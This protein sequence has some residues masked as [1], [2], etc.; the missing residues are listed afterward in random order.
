MNKLKR[1]GLA[2]ALV[3]PMIGGTLLTAP[4]ASAA[5]ACQPATKVT[6]DPHPGAIALQTSFETG[7]LEKFRTEIVGDGDRHRFFRPAPLG[8]LQ[9]LPSRDLGRRLGCVDVNPVLAF[10]I[11]GGLRGR[12]VQHD[13]GRPAE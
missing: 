3:V 5:P 12:V 4:A 10:R 1:I 2:A 11:Q 13:Q 8:G 7:T 9:R 6:Y